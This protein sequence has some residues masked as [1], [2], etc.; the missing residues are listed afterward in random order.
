ME[1][2]GIEGGW[3]EHFYDA[4]LHVAAGHK[5]VYLETGRFWTELYYKAL[6]DPSVGA[7]KLLWG[8]DWGA[9]LPVYAQ[10]GRH[11]GSYTR[12]NVKE[13]IIRHQVDIW[14]WSVDSSCLWRYRRMTLILFWAEMQSASII[15][16]F[17]VI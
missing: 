8:T 16:S 13:G 10:P 4:S 1:H 5:N 11:P 2:A 3:W 12:Q 9:S 17:P 15:S 7:E 6:N 14:G